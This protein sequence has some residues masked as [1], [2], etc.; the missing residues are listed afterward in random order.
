MDVAVEEIAGDEQQ[1]VL[2]ALWERP[3]DGNRHEEEED[4]VE[5]VEDH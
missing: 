1:H 4:E 2:T 3:V 5:A